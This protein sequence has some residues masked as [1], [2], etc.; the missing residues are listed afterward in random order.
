MRLT[1]TVLILTLVASQTLKAADFQ[2]LDFESANLPILPPGE[3]G[4]YV[5]ISQALPGWSAYLGTLAT[6]SILYN[7]FTLGSAVVSIQGPNSPLGAPLGGNFS[8]N[9]MPGYD[10]R[11]SELVGVSLAQTGLV[12]A[13]A[14]SIFFK[15]RTGS[16]FQQPFQVT[17]A[18]EQISL[19]P[20]EEQPDHVLFAGDI[21]TFAGDTVEL[22]F[23]ISEQLNAMWV[24]DIV[25]SSVPVPEPSTWAMLGLGAVLLGSTVRRRRG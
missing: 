1:R 12:P 14:N 6:D 24:D 2:N 23:F 20:W 18:G 15:V 10:P 7:N 13:E 4:G 25:F 8:A 21:S 9:L 3:V 17:L 19:V 16:P 11:V 5:P 22:R